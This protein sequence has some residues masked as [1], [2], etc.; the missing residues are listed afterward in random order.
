MTE[1]EIL[2][3][4]FPSDFEMLCAA[5]K[6]NKAFREAC[7]DFAAIKMEI[8]RVSQQNKPNDERFLADLTESLE[9]LR[10]EI[11]TTLSRHRDAKSD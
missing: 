6:S 2:F 7:A 10:Q 3:L 8:L 4:D 9:D 1:D 11:R 5:R